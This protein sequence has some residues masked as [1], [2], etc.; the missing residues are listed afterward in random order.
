MRLGPK[1]VLFAKCV[2]L[3]PTLMRDTNAPLKW[4]SANL[5]ALL[6]LGN[7]RQDLHP[8]QKRKQRQE[9][10]A[11]DRAKSKR[12]QEMGQRRISQ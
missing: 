6:L 10:G 3:L 1:R 7:Q 11:D 4:A 2:S 5:L 8:E 12:Q 9:E